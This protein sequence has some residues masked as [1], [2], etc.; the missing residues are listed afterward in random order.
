MLFS[1]EIEIKGSDLN[2]AAWTQKLTGKPAISVGSVG[3]D[4]DFLV[5]GDGFKTAEVDNSLD[6]LTD[7]MEAGEFD[8]IA[9]GRALIANADWANVVRNG[10]FDQLHTFEKSMLETLEGAVAYSPK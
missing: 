5:E 6:K 1:F 8:L 7:R 2:L 4:S 10:E 9:V 3:L